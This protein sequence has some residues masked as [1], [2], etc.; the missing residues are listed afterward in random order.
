MDKL[1]EAR[2]AID[3]I[4][5]QMAALFEARMAAAAAVAAYKKEHALPVLDS[6]REAAV[7][8]KNLARLKNKELEPFYAAYL[9]HQLALSRQYQAQVLGRDRV[10][11]QGVEGA[12]AHIALKKL[13]PRAQ[14]LPC[15]TW[16]K[17]FDAVEAGDAAYGVLPFENSH[18]GDVSA[19]LDLCFAH[20]GL[21]VTEVCDL[22]V[23]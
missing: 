14:E 16:G 12:F 7:V 22:P 3:R 4:D 11:Y 17:V 10:A 9:R 18:A 5:A 13:F 21:Y 1:D 6:A 19:V 20:P 23:R 15:A 2:A 8:E